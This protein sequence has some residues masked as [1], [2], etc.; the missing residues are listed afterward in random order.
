MGG[1]QGRRAAV[2]AFGKAIVAMRHAHE[3]VW[4]LGCVCTEHLVLFW[5]SYSSAS[6]ATTTYGSY[7]SLIER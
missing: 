1:R 5:G 3:G 6:K 4:V 7:L 2:G